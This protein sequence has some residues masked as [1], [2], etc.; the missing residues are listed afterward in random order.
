MK[1]INLK[2]K[3]INSLSSEWE[4]DFAKPG[5]SDSGIFVI[6]GK[7][8]AGKTSI[9]DAISLALYGRTP[10]MEINNQTNDVMTRGKNDCY[11]EIT[12]E[13]DGKLW[14]SSFK[15]ERT[16]TGNLKPVNRLIADNSN[17]IYADSQSNCNKKI[18]EIIGL[19]FAQFTKVIMLAQG[20]FAAFLEADKNSKGELLEQIT[21]TEI[22][23][24]ISRKIFERNKAEKIKLER[25]ELEI[26]AIKILS[27]EE[28]NF[29]IKEIDEL[30]EQKKLIDSDLKIIET[31]KRW[32]NDLENLKKLIEE[33]KQKI[34]DLEQKLE[35]SK[36]N[37][38]QSE[39]NLN[40]LKTEKE[41]IENIL[42]KV[43]ELDTKISE[44][45]Q[46]LTPV[47]QAIYN[48][49]KE[50]TELAKTFENKSNN[51][52]EC[53]KLLK[54]RED[55]TTTN[56]KFETLIVEF[57]AIENQ[58]LQINALVNDLKS[59]KL[60]Y[61]KAE[62]D[63][64]TNISNSVKT[65]NAFAEKEKALFEKERELKTKRTELSTILA[66][67]ELNSYRKEIDEIRNFGVL[68]GNFI[69]IEKIIAENQCEIE[70]HNGTIIC[71]SQSEKELSKKL[72]EK[73]AEAENIKKQ[74]E[75]LDENIK[76]VKTIQSL[77][78]HRKMLEDG[79]ACPLCGALQHPF[80]VGNE[81]KIG[82]RE[83]ELK[84]L[85]AQ[86]QNM[87]TD[88][89]FDEKALIKLISDRDNAK[90]NKENA[91][92]YL[93]ENCK[94][95]DAI[96]V[97][98]KTI[99]PD[100][101]I[102]TDENK[103]NHLEKIREQKRN[104]YKKIE[105][106][107]I[108]ANDYEKTI[109]ILQ[110]NEI[111]S[112]QQ[113][114]KASEK[115]KNE[116]ET[117]QKLAEQKL[118][119]QKILLKD[120]NQKHD[121]ENAK[122]INIFINYGVANIE[123]LEKCLTDWNNNKKAIETLKEQISN[124]AIALSSTNSEIASN[125]AQIDAKITEKQ[126][127]ETEKLRLSNERNI[128]FG[129]KRVEDEEIRLKQL[130]T[131]AE[132]VKTDAEKSKADATTELAKYKAVISEKEKDLAQKQAENISNKT[133]EE[134]QNEYDA[135]KPETDFISQKIGANMQAL[136]SNEENL[137]K[138]RKK[139]EDKELQNKI[140]SKWKSL[141]ELIGSHDGKKYRNFAQALT[142]EHLLGLAN[143]QLQKMSERYILKRVGDADKNPYELLVI[144]KFQNCE[145][146]TAQNLSGG[147]TFI[148]SLSL[149]L[150]LA[151]MASNNM[152]IDTMFIDEGF[153][154]LDN[155]YLDV[156]LS[157]LSN[158]QNEGKLI[159]VISHLSELKE[160]IA[161]HI[162]VITK[163]NGLSMIEGVKRSN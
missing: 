89:L 24:E 134:L 64:Q 69:D 14:K 96:F 97:K 46:V 156:A 70:K 10:R 43:R 76:L 18:I 138:N 16:R 41:N 90:T 120:A 79:K 98:I 29:Y 100:F 152:K 56:S 133:S 4:I 102:S 125:Q 1:I 114:K 109:K 37:Y 139:L 162:E 52:N 63:L 117:N 12:F 103:I 158:L 140:C 129:D 78:E 143:R 101:S 148:V 30:T 38:E 61:E 49:E 7:T 159:G 80:A 13:I 48:L 42:I 74:I 115:E 160:R 124:L 99:K 144:D 163:G 31:A 45:N 87:I 91:E 94:K 105:S 137:L 145:E 116:A 22:Y 95:R 86:E 150:G 15:Q 39:L 132:T 104:D 121:D 26:G 128:L 11:S 130:L 126:R 53:C 127:F 2:F 32:L 50:K 57:A 62:K 110:D 142:F 40:L 33:A 72:S 23:S 65:L 112:L 119:N 107:I 81:P 28:E 60:D 122:L 108:K 27:E 147:E 66:E 35:I 59:R 20:S 83:K 8:G 157:A 21:G 135:K 47:L 17:E 82:D 55:W 73:K 3:N 106:I 75:L 25:L 131:N 136:K 6:T 118:E 154:S 123:S 141:D 149:A 85:K 92:K 9:L 44:K 34:P 54:Q 5:F 111:P 155:D 71:T 19:T 151:N 77:D 58:Y 113:A 161:T 36:Q 153:G 88:V 93:S 84:N 146:R 51:K 68:I 67:K